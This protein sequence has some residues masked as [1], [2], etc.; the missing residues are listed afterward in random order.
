M[1]PAMNPARK[2][3]LPLVSVTALL[4][5]L[6][7][8][9]A[10]LSPGA[11]R[12]AETQ[13]RAESAPVSN[14]AP[15]PGVAML[16]YAGGKTGECFGDRFLVRF[17]ETTVSQ[18]ARM[19]VIPVAELDVSTHGVAILTGEGLFELEPGEAEVLRGFLAAGGLLI[20]STGCSDPDWS[21]SFEAAL[22]GI[23]PEGLGPLAPLPADHPARTRVFEVGVSAYAKGAP[24]MPDLRGAHRDDGR[25][26]VV[27]S[28]EGL[29][30]TIG[31]EDPF[32][33][34]CGGNEVR[35]AEEILVNLLAI[36]FDADP[37]EGSR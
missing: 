35:S 8:V 12:A 26:A 17:G 32:C 18:A 36:G 14:S 4:V 19:A 2:G 5:A 24:R 11:A 9:A 31:L 37:Q 29:N 6:S 15:A 23:L 10:A 1:N 13:G 30:D 21:R 22:P 25:L 33:C 28:P 16:R 20:A 34:C 27:W 7:A 3:T